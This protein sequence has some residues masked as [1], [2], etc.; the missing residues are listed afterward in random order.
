MTRMPTKGRGLRVTQNDK[1]PAC[2]CMT[3]A[4]PRRTSAASAPSGAYVKH[5]TLA[6]FPASNAECSVM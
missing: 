1:V 2:G 5:I 4:R 6:T 3:S